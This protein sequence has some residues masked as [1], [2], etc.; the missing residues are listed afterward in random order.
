MK[1]TKSRLAVVPLSIHYLRGGSYHEEVSSLQRGRSNEG[2][3]EFGACVEEEPG[4]EEVVEVTKSGTPH[5]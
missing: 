3:L 5:K 1:S 2:L 4:E